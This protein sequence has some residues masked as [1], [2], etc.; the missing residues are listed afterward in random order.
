MVESQPAAGNVWT[1]P[2]RREDRLA[3]LP[4]LA[5]D[6]DGVAAAV[7]AATGCEFVDDRIRLPG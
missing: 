4:F 2:A 1:P 3:R 7:D 5:E 6:R